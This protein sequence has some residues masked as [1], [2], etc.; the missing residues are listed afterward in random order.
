MRLRYVDVS[1]S[2]E[3]KDQF[4]NRVRL[5]LQTEQVINVTDFVQTDTN[6]GCLIIGGDRYSNVHVNSFINEDGAK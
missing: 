5:P 4:G 6:R 3:G 2:L 1:I